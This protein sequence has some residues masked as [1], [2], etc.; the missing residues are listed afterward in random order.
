MNVG[1][2]MIEVVHIYQFVIEIQRVG[3]HDKNNTPEETGDVRFIF[4][5]ILVH[6]DGSVDRESFLLF[7]SILF[8][9]LCTYV[10]VGV[11]YDFNSSCRDTSPH[12][13][14]RASLAT[15]SPDGNSR[16]FFT[17]RIGSE[18]P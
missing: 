1:A 14:R 6:E 12:R 11:R 4:R 8:V 16:F 5:V 17:L 3:W 9:E 13:N 2:L 18:D 7:A 15:G 10:S